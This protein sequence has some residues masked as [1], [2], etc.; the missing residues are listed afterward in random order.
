V[1]ARL[2]G[3]A[4]FVTGGG[5]GIGRAI[6]LAMAREG[7]HVAIVD[8]DADSARDCAS[9]ISKSES[10]GT[11]FH[12]EC[13]I[14]D[15]Q[16]VDATV[17]SFVDST[18][19]LDI[20]V[21]NAVMF[22]Y[23]PLVDMDEDVVRRMLEVGIAGTIFSLQAA[24]PHLIA[25]GGGAVVNLSSVAV[26][27]SIKNA[28]V[29]TSIKGAIDALTRQQAVELAPYGIRVN[30]LAP[31]PVSTPGAS[32]VID[33]QGWRDRAARTPLGRLATAEQIGSAAVYLA[34]DEAST[35]TGVTLKIDGGITIAGP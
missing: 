1:T 30:A 25:S 18:G 35:I 27:F 5:A 28:A 6:S 19:R 23:A 7:A 4:A 9:E 29:Y 21:N 16:A 14:S 8:I 3:Q 13:D 26:S 31:G 15:R 20:L 12:Y 34:S 2:Q 11:A 32:S 33:E 10:A 24:T 22:H 17:S